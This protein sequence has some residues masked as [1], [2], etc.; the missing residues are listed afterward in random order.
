MAAGRIAEQE[1]LLGHPLK[2]TIE[3]ILLWFS[4]P[5]GIRIQGQRFLSHVAY[6]DEIVIR[7]AGHEILHPPFPMD[8]A[9]AKAALSVLGAD[10]LFT[11]IVAE[12]DPT[13]GYNS[14]EGV[15]NEDTV[16]ALDQIIAERLGC[17]AAGR[18]DRHPT[19]ACIAG[20][21]AL[22]APGRGLRP[23]RPK[24]RRWGGGEVGEAGARRLHAAAARCWATRRPARPL[25]A[26]P[27]TAPW[28][29][30]P[31]TPFLGTDTQAF[32]PAQGQQ[33]A[34]LVPGQ[35]GPLRARSIL[36]AFA[37]NCARASRP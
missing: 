21:G 1:R 6:P 36:A 18:A 33:R 26:Y 29:M 35:Q 16:Q 25:P 30:A 10:P 28:I 37:A 9:A 17:R 7:I 4:K 14:L 13:F 5:H 34:R 24:M 22:R 19:A 20:G 27:G 2:P 8:G 15:L 3:V 23:D 31:W 32:W 11:R 12:H